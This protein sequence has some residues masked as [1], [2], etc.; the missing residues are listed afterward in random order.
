MERVG[1]VRQGRARV[2]RVTVLGWAG[3]GWQ[4]GAADNGKVRRG[5]EG[6]VCDVVVWAEFELGCCWS[7]RGR[8]AAGGQKLGGWEGG[9]AV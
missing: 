5:R 8:R 2:V 1:M 4:A 7:E 3:L 6:Y 9:G